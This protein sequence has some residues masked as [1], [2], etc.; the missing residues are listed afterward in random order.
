MLLGYGFI[1]VPTGIVTT[2]M[3]LAT[4]KRRQSNESCPNCGREGHD[5][6]A[7]HCKYCGERI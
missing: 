3:A 6:D 1:A 4:K 2:E 7:K 5:V